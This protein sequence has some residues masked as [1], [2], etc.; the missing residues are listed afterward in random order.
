MKKTAIALVAYGMFLMLIGLAGYLSNP[1][2]AKTALLSGGTFGLLN[3]G[4]GYLT[5][6]GWPRSVPVA[7]A[8]AACLAAVFSWRTIVTWMA[9]AGGNEE[10]L[11]AAVLISSMLA[12]SVWMALYLAL[13]RR[14]GIVA[15]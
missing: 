8:V 4:L 6:R 11:V 1:E 12:A 10:K 5:S 9:F 15:G 14:R 7:L 2:K 13:V 3:I